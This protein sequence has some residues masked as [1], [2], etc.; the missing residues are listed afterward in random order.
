MQ[1]MIKE[2]CK[3]L[4]IGRTFYL[5]YK[6]I[7][8]ASNEEFLLKLLEQELVQREISRKKRLLEPKILERFCRGDGNGFIDSINRNIQFRVFPI[9]L[10]F[11]A[12]VRP[13]RPPSSCP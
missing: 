9:V 12:A 10:P 2:Y 6:D 4:K 1:T 3:T 11:A 5:D 13:I 7:E 8:A